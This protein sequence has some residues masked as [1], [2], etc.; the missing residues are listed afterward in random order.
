LASAVDGWRPLL[1]QGIFPA[2]TELERAVPPPVSPTRNEAPPQEQQS[3]PSAI[4]ET[5]VNATAPAETQPSDHE[6]EMVNTV[7]ETT[8]TANEARPSETPAESVMPV[9]SPEAQATDNTNDSSRDSEMIVEA[10]VRSPTPILVPE[11]EPTPPVP[12]ATLDALPVE[13][14]QPSETIIVPP[15]TETGAP[16]Q[17]VV[18]SSGNNNS[19]ENDPTEDEESASDRSISPPPTSNPNEST[20]TN[21]SIAALS[22]PSRRN[23][24]PHLNKI[25]RTCAAEV[26]FWGARAWWIKERA[27]AAES[28]E[29]AE[30][31]KSRKDCPELGRCDKEDDNGAF[32]LFLLQF[33]L[34]LMMDLQHM[35]G[36]V[37]RF[38]SR[39]DIM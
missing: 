22:S 2:V 32:F 30:N 37:R 33:G 29:L 27:K 18:V 38:A 20:Q 9:I 12:E 31:V 36:N 5:P 10:A 14:Q 23:R 19:G 8:D 35:P 26:F 7:P 28:G 24:G 15:N 3:S 11:P 39:K 1:D 25:C 13:V 16:E 4:P 21:T 34:N 17:V 6:Q